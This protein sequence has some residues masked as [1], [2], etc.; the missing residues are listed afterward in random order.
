MAATGPAVHLLLDTGHAHLGRRRSGRP[1]ARATR[2]ASATSTPRTCARDVMAR[3]ER[4]GLELPRLDLGDGEDSASTPCRATAW[5]T[6]PR[7]SASLQGYSG[8]VVVEAEQ[9]PKE[10]QPPGL[11]QEG[12]RPPD[13]AL[14][15][16]GG[17]AGSRYEEA[18]MRLLAKAD[19]ER[20]PSSPRGRDGSRKPSM[21]R[22][23][24]TAGR[25][26]GGRSIAV[27]PASAGWTYVGFEVHR[28]PAGGQRFGR[29]GRPWRSASCSSPARRKV[30]AG[31]RTSA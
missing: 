29:H 3:S 4:R 22:Q 25:R 21:H 14:L 6:M 31:G 28:L 24:V 17:L 16:E 30:G 18:A 10:G 27:T 13:R 5:S 7:C 19:A 9:D 8:W 23:A 2:T 20:K 15:A 1:R 26:R 12:R 11:C